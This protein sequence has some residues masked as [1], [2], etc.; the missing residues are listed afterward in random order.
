M[1]KN[2][3]NNTNLPFRSVTRIACTS[4]ALLFS[5]LLISAFTMVNSAVVLGDYSVVN[6]GDWGSN[7]SRT[8]NYKGTV[9][10]L[11]MG[12]AGE[13]QPFHARARG[14]W[15]TSFVLGDNHIFSILVDNEDEEGDEYVYQTYNMPAESSTLYIHHQPTAKRPTLKF[16][17]S[18][19]NVTDLY[20]YVDETDIIANGVTYDNGCAVTFDKCYSDS[21]NIDIGFIG[22]DKTI[23]LAG[24]DFK[25]N[26]IN[27]ISGNVVFA[28]DTTFNAL[29]QGQGISLTSESNTD[30]KITA[31]GTLTFNAPLTIS[32]EENAALK[33]CCEAGGLVCQESVFISSGRVD[34]QG[35]MQASL[36][37]GSDAVFS[38]GN[39][40]GSTDVTGNFTLDSGA[41]LLMEIASADPE[42]NDSLTVSALENNESTGRIILDGNSIIELVLADN[43]SLGLGES[44]TAVLT[45]TNGSVPSADEVLS[46]IKTSDFTDLEYKEVNGKYSITGR[47]F[48]ASEIPEPSTWAL[49]VLGASGLLYIRKREKNA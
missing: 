47:R 46:L 48:T 41:T 4:F 21:L 19:I 20:L 35:T 44:F 40:P 15:T 37:I 16:T 49:L 45:S 32:S 18:E 12:Y 3:V 1:N 36:K 13:G 27:V 43:S 25:T 6:N 7:N 39:S 26:E 31:Q 10:S 38:P 2:M 9:N 30:V 22:S 5:V 14:T 28:S 29:T 23:T 42:F 11:S 17:N 24:N 33:I 8:F 34:V